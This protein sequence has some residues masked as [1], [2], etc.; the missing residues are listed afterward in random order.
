MWRVTMLLKG[1]RGLAAPQVFDGLLKEHAPLLLAHDAL[2]SR[3]L[4]KVRIAMA[5]DAAG[6]GLPS[7]FDA[8]AEFW[9]DDEHAAGLGLA[10]LM[11]DEKLAASAA[12]YVAHEDTVAWMGEYL[13]KLQIDGVKL[14]LTVTGDVADGLSISEALQYWSDVHP[15]V[16][17]TARDFWAYLRLYAQIHGRRVPGLAQYRPMAADVGFE[18]AEDFVAA[19]S[20]PQYLSIV[21]PDEMK[22]SKPGDMFAFATVDQRTLLERS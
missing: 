7:M 18:T 12:R 1:A 5:C 10:L 6:S 15:V 8:S 2:S 14:K 19:F 20:H 16:A 21:R 4:K 17:R 11:Q 22:F 9:F 3:R 13:P